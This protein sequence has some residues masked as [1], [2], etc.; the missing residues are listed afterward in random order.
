MK[1]YLALI[2]LSASATLTGCANGGNVD[3][4]KIGSALGSAIDAGKSYTPAEEEDIGERVMADLLGAAPLVKDAALQR[5]VNQVGMWVAMQSDKPNLKWRFGVTEDNDINSFAAPGGFILITKGLFDKLE[6]E[7]ELASVLGHEIIHVTKGHHVRAMK[8][9]ATGDLFT[10]LAR[11]GV[12]ASGKK[13]A[14]YIGNAFSGGT[15]IFVRGF[16]K[17]DEYEADVNGMVLAARAGYNPYAL[18]G[19]LTTLGNINPSDNAVSLLFKTHPSPRERL[20]KID[21][22]VGDKLERYANGIE[23]TNTFARLQRK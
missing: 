10:S 4:G 12:D 17:E 16:D 19:V 6:S 5:Y 9:S 2:A 20:D 22:Y 11:M 15:E 13:N 8:A 1:K 23:N 14:K 7:A 18:P 21:S 3:L